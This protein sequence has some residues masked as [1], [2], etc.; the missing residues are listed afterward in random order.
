VKRFYLNKIFAVNE[1][2]D[3]PREILHHIQVLRLKIGEI[4]ELFDGNNQSY[5]AEIINLDKRL[6]NLKIIQKNQLTSISMFKL[7]LAIALVANDKMDLIIQ[8]AVELGVTE[9]I[10]IFSERSAR[11]ISE[12][13]ANRL[14]HWQN[15]VINSCCQC[16]QNLLP[17]ISL[18]IALNALYEKSQDYDIKIILN[19]HSDLR[20]TNKTITN[21]NKAILLVG[22]EGGFTEMEVKL[23]RAHNY[24][25]LQLGNLIMRSE[26]AVIAGLSTLNLYLKQWR[27]I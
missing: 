15:I 16:G 23:A 5:Q 17:I 9:I 10:P 11:L 3:V 24:Q 6:T 8:K 18:P 13:S 21:I 1:I 22:P 20:F 4:V 25:E 26:T 7:S 14:T 27:T 2:I 12:R 19:P